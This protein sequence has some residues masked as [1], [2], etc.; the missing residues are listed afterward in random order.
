MNTLR[1]CIINCSRL[2]RISYGFPQLTVTISG[3]RVISKATVDIY[4][5]LIESA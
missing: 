1:N 2:C 5:R 4:L 3:E